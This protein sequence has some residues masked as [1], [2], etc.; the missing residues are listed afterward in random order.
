LWFIWL[1]A[2]FTYYGVVLLTTELLNILKEQQKERNS[3]T[4][5]LQ[6]VGSAPAPSSNSC[7]HLDTD[8]YV[9]LLWTSAAEFPGILLTLLIIEKIGRKK[10]IAAEF[11]AAV[12]FFF[13]MFICPINKYALLSFIFGARGVVVGAFQAIVVYTP[14]VYPT[15]VRALGM[16]TCSGVARLGAMITPFVAEVLLRASIAGGKGT[17]AAVSLLCGVCA[18]LLPVETKGRGLQESLGKT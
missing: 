15:S 5:I 8:D 18:L 2:A 16:G 7:T 4:D 12:L 6:C 14:E 1:G 13:L 10:T 17:Y 11:F 9:E 3:S